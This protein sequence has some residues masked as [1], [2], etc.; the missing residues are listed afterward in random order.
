MG[1]YDLFFGCSH[2]HCSFPMTI[3]GQLPR[4]DVAAVSGTHVVCLECGR[5]FPYDW[6]A[7]KKVVRSK[8]RASGGHE[9]ITI[10]GGHKA[11]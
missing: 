5:E 11:A 1:L 4:G 7:M 8:T 6:K 10:F 3:K 9:P 2:K